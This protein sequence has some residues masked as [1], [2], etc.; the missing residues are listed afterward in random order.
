[1]IDLLRKLIREE[2]G[3]D[4]KSPIP[5]TMD[6]KKFPGIHVI[7]AADPQSGGYLC[8]V[9]VDDRD[10]LSTNQIMMKD[11]HSAV[12][13]CRTHAEDIRRKLMNDPGFGSSDPL[14]FPMGNDD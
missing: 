6:W 2:I 12:F 5:D 1:M 7:M 8:Q 13:W 14:S 3:R 11:E 9:K 4:L 10:D